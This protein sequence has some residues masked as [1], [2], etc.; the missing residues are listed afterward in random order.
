[1]EYLECGYG[2]GKQ[3]NALVS[4]WISRL[5]EGQFDFSSIHDH[6]IGTLPG[7]HLDTKLNSFGHM[8]L[9]KLLAKKFEKNEL[10]RQKTR[11]AQFSSIGSL[12]SNCY[13]WLC[14]E[15]LKSLAGGI[16]FDPNRKH[17]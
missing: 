4:Y 13:S 14:D 10:E 11:I 2:P 3:G 9:R 12:G 17:S 16:C 15:F 1:M 8:K 6:L 5:K 7:R